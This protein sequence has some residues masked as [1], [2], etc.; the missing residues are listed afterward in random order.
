M[1]SQSY[2]HVEYI[3]VDGRSSDRTP[4][5]LKEHN[6]SIS[7]WI[8][9]PDSGIY[10]AMNKGLK[11]ATGDYVGFLNSDDFLA[12]ENAIQEIA[13]T[14]A[15]TGA[16]ATHGN[17]L[18]VDENDPSK[19]LRYYSSKHFRPWHLRFGNMPPHATVYARREL[20]MLEKGFRTDLKIA[21]DFDLLVRIF[22]KR[23]VSLT[24]VPGIISINRNGGV[25]TRGINSTISINREIYSSLKS[26]EIN[27][28]PTLLWSRYLFKVWQLANRPRAN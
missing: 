12:S 3:V 13:E 18:I 23:R 10:D 14:L 21:A 5:I 15:N 16:D 22:L 17:C 19:T 6:A 1:A 26:N 20:L 9:E 4:D 11:M 27:S 2:P 24:Y 28:H 8:S 25:S 7:S